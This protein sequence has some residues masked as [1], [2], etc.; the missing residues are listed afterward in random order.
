MRRTTIKKIPLSDMAFDFLERLGAWKDATR[1]PEKTKSFLRKAEA[2]EEKKLP[3]HPNTDNTVNPENEGAPE[4]PVGSMEPAPTPIDHTVVKTEVEKGNDE[5]DPHDGCG[6]PV[7]AA[8][9]SI[10]EEAEAAD[11]YNKRANM[12]DNEHAREVYRDIAKEE[13]V[14]LGEA[15]ELLS[16]ADPELAAEVPKGMQEA[17]GDGEPTE[18]WKPD[19]DKAVKDRQ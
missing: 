19:I 16:E 12:V 2:E 18:E 4:I 13:M 5:A 1:E 6:C 14:H 9:H 10:K 11:L 7:S 3:N 15:A 17:K 8:L